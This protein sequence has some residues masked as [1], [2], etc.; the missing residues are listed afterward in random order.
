MYD[1]EL[2]ENLI[3]CA[4]RIHVNTLFLSHLNH[5]QTI[6][7]LNSQRETTINLIKSECEESNLIRSAIDKFVDLNK[8]R[9]DNCSKLT[10]VAIGKNN[11]Y[12]P[13]ELKDLVLKEDIL[14][15]KYELKKHS[16]GKIGFNFPIRSNTI[17]DDMVN[18]GTKKFVE[19]SPIDGT[20]QV[21]FKFNLKGST[22]LD[23]IEKSKREW[24]D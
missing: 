10:L 2:T 16:I 23:Q 7:E 24:V 18:S 21:G 12:L 1:H 5:I 13:E 9:F 3:Y 19:S 15:N 11:P 14:K 6:D 8:N 22:I 20:T 17:V 4:V